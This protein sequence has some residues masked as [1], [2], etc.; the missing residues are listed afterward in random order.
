MEPSSSIPNGRVAGGLDR[1]G[2]GVQRDQCAVHRRWVAV[3][4]IATGLSR[5]PY[6]HD[7]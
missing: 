5:L 1:G 7:N 3:G 6:R 4:K 2:V